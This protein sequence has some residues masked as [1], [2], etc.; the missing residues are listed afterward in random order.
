MLVRSNVRPLVSRDLSMYEVSNVD[1]KSYGS[2]VIQ[3]SPVVND[4][5]LQSSDC[6]AMREE[7]VIRVTRG[8]R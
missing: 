3:K 5:G 8:Q 6:R 2:Q 7:R 4:I 1:A